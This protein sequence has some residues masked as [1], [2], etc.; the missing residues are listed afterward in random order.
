MYFLPDQVA[1]YD[2]KRISAKEVLQLQLFVTDEASAIQWLKASLT[3]KPKTFQELH[4]QFLKEIGGWQKH[5]K[6]LE[7]SELLEQNFLRYDGKGPI[8]QQIVSW[9]KQSADLCKIIQDELASGRSTEKNG[10]LATNRP[11]ESA[12]V[13]PGP[14]QG[15][16][17]GEAPRAGPAA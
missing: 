11:R 6:P 1:E 7:L 8:P 10:Q 2:R 15:R 13:R 4:P 14:Q 3:K 16:R 5:E 17:L 12:L 9:M